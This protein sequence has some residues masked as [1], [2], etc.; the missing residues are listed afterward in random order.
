MLTQWEFQ[1][2]T[3]VRFGRGMARKL[4][5]AAAALGKTALVVGYRDRTGLEETYA[6]AVQSL[7]AAGVDVVEFFQA[8]PDPD[9]ELV[10]EGARLAIQRGCD[11][12]VG[13]GGGSAID[14]AK[15]IAALAAMGGPLWDYTGANPK[16][17][18]VDKALPLVAVPTTAGT[19]S[20]VSDVAVFTCRGV[21]SQ[22]ETPV[23]SFIAGPAVAPA[24]AIVDPDLAV[25]SPPSLTAACGADALGHAIE[26]CMSRRAGPMS[27]LL[28]GHAAGLIVGN[29]AQAVENPDDPEPREPLALAATLAGAAF[30]AAGVTMSHAIAQAL[31]AILHVP[32]GLGV[33]LATPANLRYNADKCVDVYTRLADCCGIGGQSPQERAAA[34]V[35]RVVGLLR[36]VGL[37]DRV[38][39][40]P[41][42]P[43]DLAARLA[44]NAVEGTPVPLVLNP[45]KVSEAELVEIFEGLLER[46]GQWAGTG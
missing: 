45:R 4:G 35:D 21:G 3:R 32:H 17:R 2:P 9:A 12:V 20:E 25:G 11:V 15:G 10:E 16:S 24:V 29:L 14:A 41:G 46:S 30:S 5:D 1:L 33:A 38:K 27:S 39:V 36:S 37:P 42:A 7:T 40:P 34:F 19:G 28:A 8:A 43:P 26:S 13:L 6:R 22:P 18:P 23:K 44:R 31:G